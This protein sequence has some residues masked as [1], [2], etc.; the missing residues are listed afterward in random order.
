MLRPQDLENIERLAEYLST[1]CDLSQE[2]C[3]AA[4][5]DYNDQ[6]LAVRVNMELDDTFDG[7][8][9]PVDGWEDY[10]GDA[11][12]FMM[13]RYLEDDI[14]P[15]IMFIP[16]RRMTYSET[17]SSRSNNQSLV[18]DNNTYE[19]DTIEEDEEVLIEHSSMND[20]LY[21]AEDEKGLN[22]DSGMI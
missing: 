3:L 4:S 17:G 20:L 8:N 16:R 13:R 10:S 14:R 18:L 22:E 5:K 21:D 15:Q 12:S 7:H 19:P 9:G 2:E 6:L 11:G 1:F